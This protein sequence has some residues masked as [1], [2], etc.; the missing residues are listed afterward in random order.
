M[1]KRTPF[2]VL[3]FFRVLASELRPGWHPDSYDGRRELTRQISAWNRWISARDLQPNRL[4]SPG[5]PVQVAV[6][7]SRRRGLHIRW[8]RTC[9]S[10][11][12]SNR[13]H[14]RV[15]YGTVVVHVPRVNDDLIT[16]TSIRIERVAAVQRYSVTGVHSVE[17]AVTVDECACCCERRIVRDV[18]RDGNR[19]NAGP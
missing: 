2:G 6:L 19:C 9:C 3:F 15:R 18:N 5:D 17:V 8:Y 4:L 11:D 1:R 16:V 10:L 12:D 7:E 14:N 13:I